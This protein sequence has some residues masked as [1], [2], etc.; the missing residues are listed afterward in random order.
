M[1]E[2]PKIRIVVAEDDEENRTILTKMLQMN[3][4]EIQAAPDGAAAF[5]LLKAA[6]PDLLISDINMP[7]MNGLELLR[8]VREDEELKSIRVILVTGQST[9][10]EVM[11]GI[12]EGADHYITKPFK[13]KSVLDAIKMVLE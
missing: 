9:D 8:K 4:Y 7:V 5:E 2:K 11:S 13:P 6:K 3:G 12:T 1:E 10:E